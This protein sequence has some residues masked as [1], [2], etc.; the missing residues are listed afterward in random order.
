M[1]GGFPSE[2]EGAGAGIP[3][4]GARREKEE[5]EAG[6]QGVGVEESS[7]VLFG[8]DFCGEVS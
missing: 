7:E 2:R 1:I 4:Y 5:D 8:E 3:H 6:A